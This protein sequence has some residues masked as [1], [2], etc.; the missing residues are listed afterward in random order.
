MMK[1]LYRG[2]TAAVI[3]DDG[4]FYLQ[5]LNCNTVEKEI[6]VTQEELVSVLEA[7]FAERRA[8]YNEMIKLS[9]RLKKHVFDDSDLVNIKN[10]F[11]N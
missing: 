10:L 7:E 6:K 4:V 2:N 1:F 9:K 8:K 11:N 5:I 3:E